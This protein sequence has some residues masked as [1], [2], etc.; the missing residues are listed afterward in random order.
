[1]FLPRERSLLTWLL[2]VIALHYDVTTI[3]SAK[4]VRG[5]MLTSLMHDEH[6]VTEVVHV[7]VL[8]VPIEEMAVDDHMFDLAGGHDALGDGG[9]GGG[10]GGRGGRDDDGEM[11]SLMMR[12]RSSTVVSASRLFKY[13][14]AGAA[15][16]GAKYSKFCLSVQVFEYLRF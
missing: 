7:D 5:S 14:S 4:D 2:V 11:T 9:G 3:T 15:A 6:V 13:K 1:M 12:P 10:R 16:A 8:D